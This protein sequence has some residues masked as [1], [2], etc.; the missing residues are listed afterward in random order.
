MRPQ[1]LPPGISPIPR[2][3]GAT[4]AMYAA[5]RAIPALHAN[6]RDEARGAPDAETA[7]P[8]IREL[9]REAVWCWTDTVPEQDIARALLALAIVAHDAADWPAI[10]RAMRDERVPARIVR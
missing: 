9:M 1:H 2:A 8:R 6:L 7:A 4:L 3:C 5:I 10:C